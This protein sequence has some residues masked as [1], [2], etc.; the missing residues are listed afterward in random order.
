M[1]ARIARLSRALRGSSTPVVPAHSSDIDAL[2]ASAGDPRSES[3]GHPASS[4]PGVAIEVA[5]GE[6]HMVAPPPEV[7]LLADPTLEPQA[8]RRSRLLMLL[9]VRPK[10]IDTRV[11]NIA[12]KV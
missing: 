2:V 1:N 6:V 12:T 10:I 9:R 11:R 5:S 4:T 7:V 8:P 3:S